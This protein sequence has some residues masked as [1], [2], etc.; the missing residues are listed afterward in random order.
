MHKI[1]FP[2][3]ILI[4]IVVS[5]YGCSTT[6]PV[7]TR[8]PEAP[9][10]VAMTACPQLQKLQEDARLSDIS[11]TVAVNYGTYYE[12]AV[13]TDSWIEWYQKKRHIFENIK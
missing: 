10:N 11:K 3:I 12:C 2:V 5:L 6:V 1:L 8:F 13:K 7:T 9:G 4:L